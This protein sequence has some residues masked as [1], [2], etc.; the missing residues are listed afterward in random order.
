MATTP[1]FEQI[2]PLIEQLKQH[3]VQKSQQNELELK[4]IIA[5][6]E[7]KYILDAE[8]KKSQ[9]LHPALKQIQNIIDDAFN[10]S[11]NV[12]DSSI[13]TTFAQNKPV[14]PQ[15]KPENKISNSPVPSKALPKTEKT[16]KSKIDISEQPDNLRTYCWD[17]ALCTRSSHLNDIQRKTSPTSE[18][19][20]GDIVLHGAADIN[21]PAYWIAPINAIPELT[22]LT[23]SLN[24]INPNGNIWLDFTDIN[25]PASYHKELPI[26]V[27]LQ[28]AER[29]EL[30][31]LWQRWIDLLYWTVIAPDYEVFVAEKKPQTLV[32]N[33]ENILN[34][35]LT[36]HRDFFKGLDNPEQYYKSLGH[37]LHKL[38]SVFH[39]FLCAK[40]MRFNNNEK[41]PFT[42][43]RRC[44]DNNISLW[45]KHLSIREEH[46][47][48]ALNLKSRDSQEFLANV[49]TS[50]DSMNNIHLSPT[51]PFSQIIKAEKNQVLYWTKPYWYQ[52]ELGATHHYF[53]LKG[54]V[55]YCYE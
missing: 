3:L 2:L 20:T 18:P 13:N 33:R 34:S 48:G 15:A 45:Q 5:L 38:Y 12:A 42:Y 47:A 43:L 21:S 8:A 6:E 9:P 39:Q 19:Q 35:L 51:H 10:I 40:D 11:E 1:D 7:I 14:E 53:E 29:T 49:T 46:V 4:I 41:N 23:K 52:N 22:L 54:A 26:P 28:D 27:W 50:T 16:V 30:V 24:F 31:L 25:E 36:I 44:A 32:H 37:N 55:L 17:L